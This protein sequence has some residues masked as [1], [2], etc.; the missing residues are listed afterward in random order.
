MFSSAFN[1]AYH[2]SGS[3]DPQTGQFSFVHSF[4]KVQANAGL[5]PQCDLTMSFGGL[6]TLSGNSTGLGSGWSFKLARYNR[7]G[8]LLTLNTGETY[9]VLNPNSTMPWVLSH[10]LKDIQVKQE[11]D[12]IYIYHKNGDIEILK[13]CPPFNNGYLWRYISASGRYME[14]SYVQQSGYNRLSKIS[15]SVGTLASVAYNDNG[16]K[17]EVTMYPNTSE[18]AVSALYYDSDELVRKIQLEGGENIDLDY[19]K[20]SFPESQTFYYIEKVSYPTGAIEQIDYNERLYLPYGAPIQYMPAVSKHTKV[21]GAQQ[22]SIVTTYAFP[23]QDD[24][25]G[26]NFWGY[27]ANIDWRPDYDNLYDYPSNYT[28]SSVVT[29][30]DKTITHQ[31]NKF[32]QNLS[33]IETNWQNRAHKKTVTFEYYSDGGKVLADQPP[34]YEL[35][36]QKITKYEVSKSEL[37]QNLVKSF[38]YDDWGNPLKE[39]EVTGIVKTNEY[40]PAIGDTGC[41]P[42]PF[43]MVYYIKQKMVHPNDGSSSKVYS[44]THQA[45]EGFDGKK[46]VFPST[47]TYDGN[48]RSYSYYDGSTPMLQ[49]ETKTEAVT[50]ESK[51]T[52]ISYDYTFN[53]DTI[54]IAETKTGYDGLVSGRSTTMS[55]WSDLTLQETNE[56]GVVTKYTYDLSKRLVSHCNAAGSEYESMTTY[57]Y[58]DNPQLSSGDAHIGTLVKEESTSSTSHVYYN[59]EQQESIVYQQDEYGILRQVSKKQYDNQARLLSEFNFDYDISPMDH[60]IQ[61]TYTEGITYVYGSWG[62]RKETQHN[63]GI[64]ELTDYDP[65]KQQTRHRIVR[66]DDPTNSEKVTASLSATVTTYNLFYH[67]T[68]VETFDSSGQV[69]GTALYGYD[70]F[71]RKVSI[72]TPLQATAR[73]IAYDNF[74]RQVEFE[75]FDG[76]VYSASYIDFSSEKMVSSIKIPSCDFTAGEQVYDGLS[77][78][79]SRRVNGIQNKF[80]YQGSSTRPSRQLNG[81]NQTI[82]FDSIPE[83]GNQYNRVASYS[84]DVPDGEW[85]NSSKLSENNFTYATT[86]DASFPVGRLVTASSPIASHN[87][88]YTKTGLIKTTT[89]TVDKQSKSLSVS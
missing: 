65:T 89:Q 70:G 80:S 25:P 6:S 23:Q 71:G 26:P 43:G 75:Q 78:V 44:Y 55:V 64:I 9:N 52:T 28:Y 81:R 34:T 54:S 40:Y 32:H 41:P 13:T 7:S 20:F 58:T 1:N 68:K 2:L 85:N 37:S 59:G 84:T 77:R 42:H 45:I 88:S 31:Y 51:M 22:P 17:V 46:S 39:V 48:T 5:G 82:L 50:V 21:I 86:T 53:A 15:D 33:I 29:C 66:R 76:T 73:V 38:I 60:S 12:K 35:M 30:G 57:T 8:K 4:G 63:T 49:C 67:K 74:N 18:E 83:L 19:K 24:E 47:K 27:L 3:A 16:H 72:R 87:Y 56:A 10:K 79:T 14:F 36:K 69:Y 11:Q 62:E 61:E